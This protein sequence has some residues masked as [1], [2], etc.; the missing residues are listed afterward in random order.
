MGGTFAGHPAQ[1][2]V[3]VQP[4]AGHPLAAGCSPFTGHDEHYQMAMND[5][6][7]DLFLHTASEHGTPAGGLDA[8]ARQ[9]PRLR[10]HAG[11]QSAHLAASLLSAPAAQLPHVVHRQ[12]R[13]RS[14]NM[15]HSDTPSVPRRVL[16]KT[17]LSIPVI[18]FGTQGFGNHFGFVA[19]EDAV[20]LVKHSVVLGVNHFD[21]ARC[22]GDSLRKLGLA[23]KE[24]PRG[25][26]IIT[27]RLCCH[28]SAAWGGYGDGEPEFSAERV[29]RDAEDQLAVLGIDYFDG[30]LIHDPPRME[31]TLAKGGTLA[32]LLSLKARGL[33][34][35][36]G[37]GMRPHEFHRQAIATGDVDFLLCFSDYHLLRQSAA[38]GVLPA[39]AAA[40]VGVMNGWSILRGLLTGGDPAE[41]ARLG[42]YRNEDD[43]A[44]ARERWQWC[45]DRGIDLL[46]LAL[47]FC[48]REPRIHGNPIGSLN[49]AQ[50]EQNIRAAAT[51]LDDSIWTAYEE[52]FPA[53]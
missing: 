15:N 42:N 10:T 21:C 3:T 46:Q 37:Y 1:C 26:V 13:Y 8:P 25:D 49:A 28:S 22:Y 29:V 4:A 52:S 41:T 27:G 20:A 9:R 24:I 50:L 18:P 43:I 47:Q 40:G 45:R 6:D 39:A 44:A 14:R 11:P 19:D 7:V 51:P 12:N 16:G 34:R 32:E 31:P 17:G 48:L 53:K 5:P 35:N 36:V 23:L 2:D 33:V 38:G 30:V